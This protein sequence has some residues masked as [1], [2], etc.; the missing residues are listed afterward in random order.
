M[1]YFN[2][3]ESD[4]DKNENGIL[5]ATG[6]WTH[7]MLH[8]LKQYLGGISIPLIMISELSGKSDVPENLVELFNKLNDNYE[9]IS[10]L[11]N[12][13]QEW[14][15]PT[16][17]I[18][19]SRIES[20]CFD[21][22]EDMLPLSC[23]KTGLSLRIHTENKLPADFY[24]FSEQ[25][26]IEHILMN[27]I[28]NSVESVEEKQKKAEVEISI[29]VEYL[30]SSDEVKFTVKDKGP[31]FSKPQDF[32]SIKPFCSTKKGNM[33]G[34]GLYICKEFVKILG[35]NIGFDESEERGS[36]ISFYIPANRKGEGNEKCF[37]RKR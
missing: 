16:H 35:G 37:V 25:F 13:F 19:I 17:S 36:K 32:N 28:K 3:C 24:F 9:K 26:Y 29:S 5:M 2:Y 20:T 15:D 31:G 1:T 14:T 23:L 18:S 21:N 11:V 12:S 22:V 33:R 7:I 27:L 6:L 30:D 4:P 10:F 8:E 34:L